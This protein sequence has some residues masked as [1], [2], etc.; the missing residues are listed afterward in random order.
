MV[1]LETKPHVLVQRCITTIYG[2]KIQ[3]SSV[4]E[5]AS[6][7]DRHQADRKS[8]GLK[9]AKYKSRQ[10]QSATWSLCAPEELSQQTERRHI[11][12]SSSNRTAAEKE[13]GFDAALCFTACCIRQAAGSVKVEY[14]GAAAVLSLLLPAA[15][16]IFL[17]E[18]PFT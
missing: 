14:G 7:G 17:S 6:Q 10:K 15:L 18:Q 3:Q 1:H 12:T 11:H 8:A 2:W 5:N 13:P 9:E 16:R 4:K